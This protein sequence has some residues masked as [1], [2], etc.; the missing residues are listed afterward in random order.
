MFLDYYVYGRQIPASID[1]PRAERVNVT[2]ERTALHQH[3]VNM[4]AGLRLGQRCRRWVNIVRTSIKHV[5]AA[6]S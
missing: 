6:V 1:G 2:Y 4:S 5:M 3:N